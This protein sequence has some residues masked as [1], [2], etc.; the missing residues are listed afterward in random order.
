MQDE[1]DRRPPPR[2]ERERAVRMSAAE[3]RHLERDRERMPPRIE[4]D[5]MASRYD[6]RLREL[7]REVRALR[8]NREAALRYGPHHRDRDAVSQRPPRRPTRDRY[9]DQ[10]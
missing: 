7:E 10:D 4:R 8:A 2:V 1:R 5:A 3:R 6:A 9:S